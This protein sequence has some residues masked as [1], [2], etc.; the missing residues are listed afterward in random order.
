MKRTRHSLL[1]LGLFFVGVGLLMAQEKPQL[2]AKLEEE[3]IPLIFSYAPE[4]NATE[5]HE[6]EALAAKISH[7]D[8]LDISETK[9]Y[10]LIRDLYRNKDS[11]R[12]HKA[13]L[14]EDPLD[15]GEEI[16]LTGQQL[17]EP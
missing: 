1:A 15:A 5:K 9:R 3:R 16:Q 14:V 7:I 11:K 2:E 13:L 12:L 8:S 10:K 4:Y 17:P 6:R